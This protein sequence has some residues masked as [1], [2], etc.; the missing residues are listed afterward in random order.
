MKNKSQIQN[1]DNGT[2]YSMEWNLFKMFGTII[3]SVIY[4][5]QILPIAPHHFWLAYIFLNLKIDNF[6]KY[7]NI[8]MWYII[9]Y[10]ISWPKIFLNE[11]WPKNGPIKTY[12]KF[13]SA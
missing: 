2:I 4:F 6:Q 10:S 9:W 1:W 5:S 13:Y 12:I 3:Q 11:I 7:S 8:A